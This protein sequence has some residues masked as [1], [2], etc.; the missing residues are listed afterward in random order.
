[1]NIVL[2]GHCTPD[3]F[4]LK[5]MVGRVLDDADVHV[6]NDDASLEGYQDEDATWLV[7]RILD[8]AFSVGQSGMEL[9][10]SRIQALPGAKVL[11]ISDL[12][13]HQATAQKMGARPGFGKKGLYE[14]LSA[15]RLRDAVG[16]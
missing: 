3:A 16:S 2:V 13:E 12:E 11:L 5:A 9:I 15:N 6:V 10:E 8:G 7:N 4:M 14:D 1:M